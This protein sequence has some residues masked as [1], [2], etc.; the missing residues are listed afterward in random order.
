LRAVELTAYRQT[1]I[2]RRLA[3]TKRFVELH[4]GKIWVESEY[5]K[6]SSVMFTI[7]VRDAGKPIDKTTV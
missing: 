4:G 1:T 6:G 5:G 7:P 3:C 2:F